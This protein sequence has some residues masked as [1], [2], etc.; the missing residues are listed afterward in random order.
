MQ[1]AIQTL[2]L[3]GEPIKCKK[4]LISFVQDEKKTQLY[5]TLQL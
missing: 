1:R 3:Y 4:I 2:S 5:S